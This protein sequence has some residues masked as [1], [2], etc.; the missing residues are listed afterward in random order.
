LDGDHTQ[1]SRQRP[2]ADAPVA[3]LR[4]AA[5][6]PDGPDRPLEP[7]A[8][9]SNMV[10]E[11]LSIQSGSVQAHTFVVTKSMVRRTRARQATPSCGRAHR[12]GGATRIKRTAP[13]GTP[14]ARCKLGEEEAGGHGG[15]GFRAAGVGAGQWLPRPAHSCSATTMRHDLYSSSSPSPRCTMASLTRWSTSALQHGAGWEWLRSNWRRLLI[16]A[17][18]QQLQPLASLRRRVHVADQVRQRQ[19]LRRDMYS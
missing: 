13:S 3:P 11:G 14:S 2:Q 18:G 9:A 19:P 4:P 6:P 12:T 1:G 16:S 17:H 7:K 15:G 8:R 5:W 10:P